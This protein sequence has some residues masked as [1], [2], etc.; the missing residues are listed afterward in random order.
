[1]SIQS[2][3][4]DEGFNPLKDPF[5]AG[6]PICGFQSVVIRKVRR[7]LRQRT[8]DDSLTRWIECGVDVYK[9]A[10]LCDRIYHLTASWANWPNQYYYPDDN[11]RILLCYIPGLGVELND[12]VRPLFKMYGVDLGGRRI[13]E[14]VDLHELCCNKGLKMR[15]LLAVVDRARGL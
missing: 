5:L 6:V 15:E 9:A 13:I 8:I 12:V 2:I 11:A 14:N 3:E 4:W 1:M 10:V 7:V